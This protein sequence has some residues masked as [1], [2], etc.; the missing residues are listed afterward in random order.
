MLPISATQGDPPI[1]RTFLRNRFTLREV[2]VSPTPLTAL[3]DGR[4]DY[5]DKDFTEGEDLTE[6]EPANIPATLEAPQDRSGCCGTM[7]LPEFTTV[8]QKIIESGASLSDE[9]LLGGEIAELARS[10][11]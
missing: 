9:D 5:S 6:L 11:K 3:A 1:Y 8:D 4:V 7:K 2:V 10:F